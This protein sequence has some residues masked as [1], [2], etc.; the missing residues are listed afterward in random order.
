MGENHHSISVK[1][2]GIPMRVRFR[3]ENNGAFFSDYITEEKPLLVID[4]SDEDVERIR[5]QMALSSGKNGMSG[6][7]FR[8]DFIERNV[9]H[10][11]VAEQ[12]VSYDVLLMHGSALCMDS[13]AFLFTAQSGVGKSTHA[14]LWREVFGDRVRMIN[15]DKPLLQIRDSD[16]LVWGSPWNGKHRLSSNICAPLKAVAALHQAAENR[17]VRMTDTEAFSVLRQRAYQAIS[18]ER[19]MAVIELEKKILSMIPFYDLWCNMRPEAA[20]VAFREMA[21]G[22]T[23]RMDV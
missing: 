9:L 14:R 1:L 18:F 22:L 5:N 2:G 23:R 10:S 11:L 13:Q 8:P 6:Q 12:L 16:V 7:K 3:F 19:G 4:P 15:D 20:E 21:S 17:V